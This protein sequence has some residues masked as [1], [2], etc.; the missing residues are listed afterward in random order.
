MIENTYRGTL[1]L[2]EYRA[3]LI[4]DVV[5][6]KLDVRGIDLPTANDAEAPVQFSDL[7]DSE[8]VMEDQKLQEEIPMESD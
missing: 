8:A 5:T 4:S 3:R 6:G 1:L 2:N 7:L